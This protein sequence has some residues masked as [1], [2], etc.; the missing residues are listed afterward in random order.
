MK[1]ATHR[2]LPQIADMGARFHEASG[3]PA[4]FNADTFT[5]FARA[6]I[7]NPAAVV[8]LTDGGMI[9]G[10]VTPAYTSSQWRMA[11]ELFWFADDGRG[12]RLLSAF[13]K[14]AS[15]QGANEVRM[16]T[17]P[18]LEAAGTILSRRGYQPAEIS[19]TK[20]V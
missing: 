9:G 10:M 17:L 15:G 13:E 2:D 11:V 14:W 18:A 5:A 3:V 4:P 19:F 8:F 1:E 20:V 6:L 12:L 16:T 7:D